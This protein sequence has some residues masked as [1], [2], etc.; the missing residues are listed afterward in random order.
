MANLQTKIG[1]YAVDLDPEIGGG[2]GECWIT[3]QETFMASLDELTANGVLTTP[4]GCE[5]EVPLAT[6][7][8][9]EQ[10]ALNHGY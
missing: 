4:Y 6:T 7:Q 1:P 3:Y 10:W 8:Q 2:L 5:H 9:I